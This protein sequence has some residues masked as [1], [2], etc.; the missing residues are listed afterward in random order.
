MPAHTLRTPDLHPVKKVPVASATIPISSTACGMTLRA[1]SWA[2][3]LTCPAAGPR[4]AGLDRADAGDAEHRP[5]CVGAAG[6]GRRAGNVVGDPAGRVQLWGDVD[7]RTCVGDEDTAVTTLAT[8]MEFDV[9]GRCECSPSGCRLGLVTCCG[10][11]LWS[12]RRPSG[13]G[14]VTSFG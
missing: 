10:W 3:E 9:E 12:I 7:V 11:S 5:G 2:W 4:G 6:C 8:S 13:T 1:G 14:A